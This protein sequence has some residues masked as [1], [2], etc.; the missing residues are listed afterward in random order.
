[1][2]TASKSF[3]LRLPASIKAE[4]E[5]LAAADG[6]SLNQFAA[7]AIAEKIGAMRS[8]EFFAERKGK[9]NW[10]AFDAIMKRRRGEPPRAGDELPD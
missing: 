3:P 10:E 5:R 4:A 1:M 9:A 7:V 2:K 6:V 8:A